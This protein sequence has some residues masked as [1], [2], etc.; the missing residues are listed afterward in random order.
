M[1]DEGIQE[2]ELADLMCFGALTGRRHFQDALSDGTDLRVSFVAYPSLESDAVEPIDNTFLP[3]LRVRR[4]TETVRDVPVDKQLR[5][6]F[7]LM[8]LRV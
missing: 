4:V 1:H 3:A 6:N 2:T 5:R 7:P 8:Q